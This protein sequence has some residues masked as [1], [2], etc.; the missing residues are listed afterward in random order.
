MQVLPAHST[1]A[2]PVL[3]KD[4]RSMTRKRSTALRLKTTEPEDDFTRIKGI[5]LTITAQLH[6][7]GVRTFAQLAATSPEKL[8]TFVKSRSADRIAKENWVGRARHLAA[9]LT[10]ARVHS[11]SLPARHSQHYETFT[12]ELLT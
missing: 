3:I 11:A 7:S 2:G 5:G 9:K 6:R 12:V 10:P 8:A 1:L 4:K